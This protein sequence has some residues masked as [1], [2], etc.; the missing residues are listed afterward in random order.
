MKKLL[1]MLM[2]L[3]ISLSLAACGGEQA[4]QPDDKAVEFVSMTFGNI[5]MSVPN[6]FGTVSEKEGVLVSGAPNAAITVT[7]ATEI[8]LLPSEW[9][10]SVAEGILEPLY[11]ATYSEIELAAFEGDVDMNGNTAVYTA[12]YGKN[13]DGVDRFVQVVR[14]YNTELTELYIITFV[15]T[16]EDAF[17]T[18]EVGQQIINS[19]TLGA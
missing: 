4:A 8:D 2:V 3:A 12:F 11:G 18:P 15:H 5:S 6:V 10:E 9:D 16:A 7:P 17:F 14:L 1:A 13:A 19:I